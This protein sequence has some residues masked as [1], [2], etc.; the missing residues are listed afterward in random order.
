MSGD[1]GGAAKELKD[2]DLAV[3]KLRVEEFAVMELRRFGKPLFFK[4]S[5]TR[6]LLTEGRLQDHYEYIGHHSLYLVSN[7]NVDQ[8]QGT[9]IK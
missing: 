5:E 6:V 4:H 1:E 3:A 9:N 2:D 8:L 7:L